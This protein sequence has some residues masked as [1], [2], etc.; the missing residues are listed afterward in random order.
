MNGFCVECGKETDQTVRGMCMECFLKDRLLLSLPDHVDLFTCTACGQ[1]FRHG[2]W[3]SSETEKAIIA[4]AKEQLSCVKEGRIVS[5]DS[6][7]ESLDDYNY[8][9]TLTCNIEIED[10]TTRAMASTI[11]RIKNTVCKICSRRTGNYYEAILQVRT[12]DKDLPS[13]LQDEVLAK[14][15]K[16]VDEAA[17]TDANAFITKME[18]VQGGVD[19]YL[20]LIALGRGLVKV[21]GDDYCA[22]TNESAKL[23]GQTRDGLDMYRVSYLV[24]IPEFHV[25]DIVRYQKHYYVLKRVSSTGGR[26]LSL[27]NFTEMP[28]RRK[29]MP[30]LKVFAKSEDLEKADIISRSGREI[31]VM[32]PADYSTKDILVPEDAEIGDSVRV[33]RID[34]ALYYVP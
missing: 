27:R 5:T 2:E 33:V 31:Q 7:V 15:E 10:F 19:V 11:V 1:F 17:S 34:R 25:G 14:V 22:E 32:D 9:V 13:D 30:E 3:A 29:N 21:L 16:F 23:V 20:S 4:V 8:M 18:I 12:M 6:S 26:L 28:L 24:R